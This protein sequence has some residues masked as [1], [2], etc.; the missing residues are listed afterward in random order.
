MI[1]EPSKIKSVIISIVS[2]SICHEVM[3]L[4]ASILVFW[5]LSFKSAF[6]L[7]WPATKSWKG[8]IC[9]FKSLRFRG[10]FL[11]Y[12]TISSKFGLSTR[13]RTFY[14]MFVLPLHS[15]WSYT[16][17][18]GHTN[19]GFIGI[20]KSKLKTTVQNIYHKLYILK[21]VCSV[22]NSF[23]FPTPNLNKMYAEWGKRR[24][25]RWAGGEGTERTLEKKYCNLDVQ[26][27]RI[28]QLHGPP[29]TEGCAE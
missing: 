29:F 10:S 23:L 6:S 26:G 3:R 16:E 18:F 14:F 25:S 15:L 28:A 2:P 13:A 20:L 17:N 19:F 24:E 27:C 4:N 7:S 9:S 11:I 12:L 8:L 5:M 1:L 21:N 22:R